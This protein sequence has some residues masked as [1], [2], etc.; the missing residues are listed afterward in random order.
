M[1][2]YIHVT[3]LNYSTLPSPPSPLIP[4]SS[5]SSHSPLLPLLSFPSPSPLLLSGI[6]FINKTSLS[7]AEHMYRSL[8]SKIFKMNNLLGLGQLFINQSF[9]DSK[10]LEKQVRLGPLVEGEMYKTSADP[11]VPKVT[12]ATP[13]K[14]IQRVLH[15]IHV[16]L[17]FTCV[18]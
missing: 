11:T 3:L 4:L 17:V 6:L 10:L 7:E 2:M 13:T 16:Q 12:T 14:I 18:L 1:Y 5:L 8:S 9:Y 15:S